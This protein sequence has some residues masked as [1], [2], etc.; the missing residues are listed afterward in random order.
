MTTNND[1]GSIDILSARVFERAPRY[2]DIQAVDLMDG[3]LVLLD[4]QMYRV[5]F[6]DVTD[7]DRLRCPAN[8]CDLLIGGNCENKF[9]RCV[10][11]T[12]NSLVMRTLKKV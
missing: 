4:D 10:Q 8:G 5:S 11:I 2:Y 6:Y 7:P 3:E 1:L 12:H 9:F